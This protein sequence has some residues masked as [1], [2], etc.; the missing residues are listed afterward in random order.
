MFVNGRRLYLQKKTTTNPIKKS[1]LWPKLS[2][3]NTNR[4]AATIK[5]HTSILIGGHQSNVA[6][7][8]ER[9]L[10]WRN[11]ILC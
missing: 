8:G 4:Y 1:I 9:W 10:Y 11:C 2:P 3:F 5:R 6:K 7:D